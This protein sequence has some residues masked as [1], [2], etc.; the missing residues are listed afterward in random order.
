MRALTPQRIPN[1]QTVPS[2]APANN[3]N[4]QGQ[5]ADQN[6]DWHLEDDGEDEDDIIVQR[7]QASLAYR[8]QQEAE[9]NKENVAEIP[10]S[11]STRS[12]PKRN[13]LLPDPFAKRVPPVD[14][15]DRES[16]ISSDE[17]FQVQRESSNTARQRLSTS[18]TKRHAPEPARPAR[19]SPKKVRVQ[20]N[21][22]VRILNGRDEV[23][24]DEQEAGLPLSQGYEDYVTVNQTARQK[25]AVVTKPPQSRSAWT[26]PETDMLYNLITEHGTSWKLLKAED[27]Q[28][29]H[30]LEARDQVALK[31]K[32]RNMKMDYLKYVYKLSDF[33]SKLTRQTEPVE[34]YH[35]ISSAYLLANYRSGD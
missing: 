26:G 6:D 16:D 22:D 12:A 14:Q 5:L 9:S 13:I 11:Q 2:P 17:G 33:S 28:Q 3:A 30:V 20:E 7:T 27:L 32:A 19:R 10:E 35:R 29:G 23:A 24:G 25:M 18:R 8:K 15:S 1:E 4:R 31:D 34:S 21:P